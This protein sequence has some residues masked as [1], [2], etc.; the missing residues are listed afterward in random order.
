MLHLAVNDRNFFQDCERLRAAVLRVDKKSRTGRATKTP[1][2][3]E[4]LLSEKYTTMR[5]NY[6]FQ[7]AFHKETHLR[8]GC[9]LV[10]DKNGAKLKPTEPN[11]NA[12]D[13]SA[14]QVHFRFGGAGIKGSMT[15]ERLAQLLSGQLQG[16]VVDETGIQGT[17]DYRHRVGQG[18]GP[19]YAFGH[20]ECVYDP[21]GV[22]GAGVA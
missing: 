8:P 21:A 6:R 5:R 12:A 18:F 16:P 7:L 15:I 19:G 13:R 11:T 3:M 9:A 20:G 17:C 14:G 2:R 22:A 1:Q 4:R 10:G